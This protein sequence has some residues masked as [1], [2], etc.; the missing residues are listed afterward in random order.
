MPP[1]SPKISPQTQFRRTT[2]QLPATA[3]EPG[4]HVDLPDVFSWVLQK[5]LISY[6]RFMYTLVADLK[7]ESV[8]A[9]MYAAQKYDVQPLVYRCITFLK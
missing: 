8:M 1:D 7:P 4:A 2:F 3:L 6:F 9:I 5:P